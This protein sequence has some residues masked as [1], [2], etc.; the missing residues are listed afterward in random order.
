MSCHG[1][2]FE[3]GSTLEDACQG[4]VHAENLG[5]ACPASQNLAVITD[6]NSVLRAKVALA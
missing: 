4:E 6:D 5:I 2:L 1:A 3:L